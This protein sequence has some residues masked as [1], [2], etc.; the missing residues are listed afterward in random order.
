MSAANLAILDTSVYI[1]NLRSGR[2][3]HEILAL[4]YVIRCSAVVLAEISHFHTKDKDA[5]GKHTQCTGQFN[6]VRQTQSMRGTLEEIPIG[7]R[8]ACIE[9][10]HCTGG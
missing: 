8:G 4:P 2:F 1:D 10:V 9:T 6:R 3:K 5:S 7:R